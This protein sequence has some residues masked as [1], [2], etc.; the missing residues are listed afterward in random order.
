MPPFLVF[1]K[2]KE[3]K[4]RT[5]IDHFSLGLEP[6]RYISVALKAQYLNVRQ[7]KLG[8]IVIRTVQC[9]YPTA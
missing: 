4:V 9:P 2:V 5:D 7:R 6:L 1:I 3:V 8:I